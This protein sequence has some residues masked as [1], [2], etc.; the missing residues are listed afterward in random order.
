MLIVQNE[1]TPGGIQNAL[2]DLMRDGIERVRICSA[3]ISTA[4]SELLFDGVR[5]SAGNH[6]RVA[7]TI[8][9]SLDFGL[10]EPEALRF[11]KEKRNCTVLVSGTSQL[12][13][14]GLTP[15]SASHAKYYLFDRPDG[16]H[17]GLVSSAN[18]TSR[19]LTINSEVGW[20][21]SELSRTELID[22]AWQSVCRPAV[23]LTDEI[24]D[25]YR[26]LRRRVVAARPVEELDSGFHRLLATPRQGR[27]RKGRNVRPALSVAILE[28]AKR[29]RTEMSWLY[30]MTLGGLIGMIQRS[31]TICANGASV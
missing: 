10:T 17:G 13:R 11:W 16:T 20:V 31:W 2:F 4:G 26:T 27:M 7:K 9:T 1:Y 19:G 12:A 22:A 18:L 30:R 5:R 21:E 23:P 3:Y 25:A 6:E 14:G 8:V 28:A 15:N 29:S 24:L